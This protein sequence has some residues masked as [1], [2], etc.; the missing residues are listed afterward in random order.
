MK[1]LIDCFT[2]YNEL[3][4]LEL[5]LTE[6]YDVVDKF[7]IIEADKTFKGDNK[8]FIFEENK[9]R[10]TK[11]LDKIIHIKIIIPDY[12]DNAWDREKFQRNSFMNTLY[13]LNLGNDD[14][15]VI[16]D[17]DEIPNP[18]VLSYIKS[19]NTKGLYKLEMDMYFA[20]LYNK[21][22]AN[23]WYHPKIVDW[24]TLK[25]RTPEECRLNFNCQWWENA[26]WHFSYFG[27]TDMI[28]NKLDSF[29]H[30]EYNKPEYKNKETIKERVEKGL[31]ILS[32]YQYTK[33]NP[34][35]NTNLPKNWRMLYNP[36]NNSSFITDKK[37]DKYLAYYTVF[38]GSDDNESFRIPEIPSLKYDCYYFTNNQSIVSRLEGTK[39]IPVF[40]EVEVEDDT[41]DSCMKAKAPKVLPHNYPELKEYTYTC[42]LDSKLG[43]LSDEVIENQ[44]YN[45]FILND[46]SMVLRNHW[47]VGNHIM[48]EYDESMKQPRYVLQKDQI[49]GYIESKLK[50]GYSSTTDQ[51]FACGFIIRNMRNPMTSEINNEWYSNI[52]ECGIQDQISFF[53]VKQNYKELIKGVGEEIFK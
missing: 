52:Q 53:F 14:L 7:L 8:R 50:D 43:R 16:T 1:K 21:Y 47:F 38:I 25:S 44:I 51:H 33:I 40:I 46:Y 49:N 4:M 42:F 19:Y 3:E 10:F 26:G 36:S 48:N 41:I 6:I 22:T 20:N 18:S 15:V 17:V 23:K 9:W 28:V 32:D 37:H 31:D 2:F 5:R 24:E 30:Q 39:W 34:E 13:S 45:N 27:G 11:F 29:S 35:D 12:L